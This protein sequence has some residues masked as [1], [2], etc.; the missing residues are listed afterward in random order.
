MGTIRRR[1][2]GLTVHESAKSGVHLTFGNHPGAMGVSK[3]QLKPKADIPTFIRAALCSAHNLLERFHSNLLSPGTARYSCW[4]TANFSPEDLNLV[5]GESKHLRHGSCHSR[6]LPVSCCLLSV[7]I[8]H[9]CMVGDR[10][11]SGPDTCQI[12]S[13]L[14]TQ[15]CCPS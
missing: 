13:R 1:S 14:H 2:T 4:Q 5:S 3:I 12:L 10:N 7:Q 8:L 11:C 15:L 9:R 6:Q